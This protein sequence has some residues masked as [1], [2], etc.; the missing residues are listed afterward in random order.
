MTNAQINGLKP[1]DRFSQT[2]NGVTSEYEVRRVKHIGTCV[3]E[4]SGA[5]GHAFASLE[6]VTSYGSVYGMSIDSD[7][8]SN[9]SGYPS[10]DRDGNRIRG[11]ELI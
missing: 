8:Y 6:A 3:N 7:E 10:H 2:F 1:G 5:F 11:Y 4:R 9:G